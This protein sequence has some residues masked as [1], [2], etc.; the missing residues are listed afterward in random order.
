MRRNARWLLRPTRAEGLKNYC[1]SHPKSKLP[2][3]P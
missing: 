2:G 1:G 3:S